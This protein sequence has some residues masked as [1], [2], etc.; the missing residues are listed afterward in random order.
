AR[1]P[2]NFPGYQ[3]KLDRSQSST[4]LKEAVVTGQAEIEHLPFA[5]GVMDSRFVMAR[6]G[7]VVGEELTRLF[8][9][10]TE[11][12]LPVVL[13]IASG[14]ARMH[15][16]ILSLLQMAEIAQAVAEH[17]QAGL[18]YCTVLTHATT[19]GVTASFAMQGDIT[20][21]EPEAIVG[22][23][24]KRV[25]EQTIGSDLPEDFQTADTVLENGFI[26]HIVPRKKQ[27][28]VLR[29]LLAA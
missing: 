7:T 15:E 29:F 16:G 23:A 3:E 2:L 12:R 18:F 13:Y 4:E 19:G 20:F 21:A 8:E 5:L 14:G 27:A 22:F 1:D 11:K 10:A 26:D 9:Q 28:P 24:G 17:S 25:I 6:M